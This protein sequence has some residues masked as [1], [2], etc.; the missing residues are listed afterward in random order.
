[1]K[2]NLAGYDVDLTRTQVRFDN[3]EASWFYAVTFPEDGSLELA[4]ETLLLGE[5][6]II[7]HQDY[8]DLSFTAIIHDKS[9]EES[10]N[11]VN[12]ND[13]LVRQIASNIIEKEIEKYESAKHKHET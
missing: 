6:A 8:A 11:I 5:F 10:D 9:D 12:R 1:M 3:H 4:G 7:E 13:K 2:I